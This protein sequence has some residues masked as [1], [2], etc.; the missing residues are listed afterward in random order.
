MEEEKLLNFIIG[1]EKSPIIK[2]IGVG[3]GGGNA[4]NHMY[5][6]GIHD[7]AFIIC[8]TDYQAII[9]SPIQT[10][11]QLGA[12][13]TEGLGAGNKPEKARMAA[14]DSLPEIE[15]VLKENTKMVFI[16][17]G[18]GGGTGTGAAP[19]VAKAAKDMGILT[20]GIVT[21][22]FLFEGKRKIA[23]ALEGVE[24]MSKYVD[25]LLVINNEKLREIYPDFELSNAFAKADDVLTNAARGIAE[26]ITV[27]GY[28]NVD[29]ADVNTIMKDGGVAIMNSGYASGEKRITKAINDALES[30]L[31]NNNDIKNAKKI[32]LSI[33]SSKTNQIKMDEVGEIHEFME[34]MGDDIEVIWGATFDDTLGDEVKITIIATGFGIGNIAPVKEKENENVVYLNE[35][36]ETIVEAPV[37]PTI[38]KAPVAVDPYE[39]YYGKTETKTEKKVFTLEEMD[40]EEYVE[41]LS[42]MSAIKRRQLGEKDNTF[43][44]SN[45][46]RLTLDDDNKLKDK[47][48]FLHNNVD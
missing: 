25:A 16:T 8:N 43:K 45:L 19:I 32:L 28:T 44:P 46:S 15:Q 4:V 5:R 9:D 17:A 3:G 29:F 22:P 27:T 7:V 13:I 11:I 1:K 6:Q 47:N 37:K 26:I 14:I 23:Q 38:N 2:V 33:Y 31:L 36:E 35:K 24:E 48:D 12:S 41:Q 18:M 40:N 42:Q 10:K 21:I 39:K 34:I 20:V 30:P